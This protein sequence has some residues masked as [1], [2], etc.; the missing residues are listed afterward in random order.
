[1]PF[2]PCGFAVEYLRE[3]IADH[4]RPFRDNP[5][6][7]KRKWFRVPEGTPF[8]P[9]PTAFYSGRWEPFPERPR[10]VGVVYPLTPEYLKPQT[11]TGFT[12]K[13][14]CGTPE[15]FARGAVFD[16][17][18]NQQYD[19]DWI[20][21]CCGR[22]GVCVFQL[23][24]LGTLNDWPFSLLTTFPVT[25]QAAVDT[26]PA[27]TQQLAT[28]GGA[29]SPP[30]AQF[31]V[32]FRPGGAINPHGV[33]V[34][35]SGDTAGEPAFHQTT[36]RTA[37]DTAVTRTQSASSWRLDFE[38]PTDT[39]SFQLDWVSR[40]LTLRG[41]NLQIDPDLLP[42]PP[43]PAPPNTL[44]TADVV[45]AGTT[46]ATATLIEALVSHVFAVGDEEGIILPADPEGLFFLLVSDDSS[47]P[48]CTLYP[49]VGWDLNG[50]ATNSSI[51]IHLSTLYVC[52][53]GGG[54]TTRWHVFPLAQP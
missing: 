1:V 24:S 11:L 52:K 36:V 18:E 34:V 2:N 9:F 48:G 22:I 25:Q 28:N 14:Y 47:N 12:Y 49:P 30:T 51:D 32:E 26:T 15:D 42:P 33:S 5:L 13:H 27:L 53:G 39:A 23:C 21:T 20:P 19:A 54:A 10:A 45:A 46:Q 50:N 4:F 43:P 35:M 31:T 40:I 44:N 7:V 17:N 16:P 29:T 38:S 3:S 6:V 37:D 41:T 8:L